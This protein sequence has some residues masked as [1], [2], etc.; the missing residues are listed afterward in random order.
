MYVRGLFAPSGHS[1]QDTD[2]W[3]FLFDPKNYGA[4]ASGFLYLR[5]KAH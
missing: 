2:I 5:H 1:F 4:G 3:L